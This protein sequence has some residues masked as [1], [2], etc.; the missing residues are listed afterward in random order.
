MNDA[1]PARAGRAPGRKPSANRHEDLGFFGRI[2][3]FFR[4]VIAELKK[5]VRPTRSEL[6]MMITVVIVFILAVMAYVGLLDLAFAQLARW[7]FG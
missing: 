3:L 7:V 1:A 5:T 4:Q 2:A 6:W